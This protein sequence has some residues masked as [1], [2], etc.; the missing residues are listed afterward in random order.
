MS[1]GISF[2]GIVHILFDTPLISLCDELSRVE[3]SNM[4]LRNTKLRKDPFFAQEIRKNHKN[5][6]NTRMPAQRLRQE[7]FEIL[8][9]F[10]G[11]IYTLEVRKSVTLCFD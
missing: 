6:G 2:R 11:V 3:C 1:R 9:W 4:V 5:L 10:F 7:V 8:E